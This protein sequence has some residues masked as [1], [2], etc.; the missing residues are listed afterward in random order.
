MAN[1]TRSRGRVLTQAQHDQYH[2]DGYLIVPDVFTKSEMQEALAA[3]D[4]I[5]Y[6]KSFAEWSKEYFAGGKQDAVADGIGA[7]A[8]FGRAQFP[9][10]VWAIDR[11]IQNETYLDIY[12]ELLGDEPSY[13]N[14]HLFVRAGPNDKRHSEHLW[15]GYHIDHDTNSFLPPWIGCGHFDYM[16]SG[17]ILHDIDAGCAPMA[18]IPGSHRVLVRQMN[19]LVRSGAMKLPNEFPD[20]RKVKDFAAP[21]P[22]MG[23]CGS[24]AFSTSYLVHAAVPFK[25]K[26]QQR[27]LW[28][29]SLG[30]ASQLAWTRFAVPYHYGDR[31]YY[32]P[33]WTKTTARVRSIFGWPAPGHPYY[34]PQTV[35]VLEQRFPGIDMSEYKNW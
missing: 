21:V 1:Q 8:K 5:T 20:I 22:M 26:T 12:C 33:F 27:S 11:L 14:G 15:E 18:V 19:E 35:E 9:T 29:L 16:G 23:S 24:A 4:M 3:V 13:L 30:R 7:K 28:T 32:V 2:R 34:T 6:G 31:D 25:D 17:I 10:G